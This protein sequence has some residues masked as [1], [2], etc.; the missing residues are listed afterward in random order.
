MMQRLTG[1]VLATGALV[2]AAGITAVFG[3]GSACAT[4]LIPHRAIYDME[5]DASQ[6]KLRHCHA[7]RSDGL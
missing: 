5:L 3:A 2:C 4:G 6:G 1:M 7:E